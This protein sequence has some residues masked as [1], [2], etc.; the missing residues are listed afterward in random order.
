MHVNAATAAP[1]HPYT[2]PARQAADNDGDGRKGAAALNDGDAAARRANQAIAQ[3]AQPSSGSVS[4][5][6]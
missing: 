3:S 5:K 6:A 2:G 1:A 4:V